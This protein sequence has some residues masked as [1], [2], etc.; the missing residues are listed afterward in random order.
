MDA[1]AA[2]CCDVEF[3]AGG[4][5]SPLHSPLTFNALHS[6]LHSPPTLSTPFYTYTQ[7]I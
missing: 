7:H 1:A 6:T 3:D 4:V 5:A 2:V